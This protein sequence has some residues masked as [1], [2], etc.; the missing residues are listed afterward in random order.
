MSEEQSPRAGDADRSEALDRLGTYFVDGYLDVHEFDQRS[1]RAATAQTRAELSSLFRDLPTASAVNQAKPPAHRSGS[2]VAAQ[3]ELDDVLARN[4]RVQA[5][6]V[7]IWTVTMITF[8]LGLFVFRWEF[9][10]VVFPI[11]GLASVANR[12]I[13]GLSDE[14]EEL[15]EE[16]SEKEQ[17]SR[18]ERLRLAAEKRRELGQ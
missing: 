9:F 10:W 12:F 7:V 3:E 11:A 4:R 18:T 15:A 8:F 2:E 1:G 17:S 6:D 5:T 16:L 14:E 13:F